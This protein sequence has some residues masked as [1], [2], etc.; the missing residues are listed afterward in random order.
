MTKSKDQII[1]DQESIE[2]LRKELKKLKCP[3]GEIDVLMIGNVKIETERS[4]KRKKIIKAIKE[5]ERQGLW[6]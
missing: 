4:K 1:K 2:E 5:A 3:K 6:K